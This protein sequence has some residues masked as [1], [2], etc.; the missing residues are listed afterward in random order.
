MGENPA[1][2][3]PAVWVEQDDVLNL[4]EA[5][6]GVEDIRQKLAAWLER[7]CKMPHDVAIQQAAK[8]TPYLTCPAHGGKRMLPMTCMFCGRGHM[9]E[10]HYPKTCREANCSKYRINNEVERI[11]L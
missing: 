11:Y 6:L 2:P 5:H 7:R 9:M 10:C 4:D 1:T 3:G 8:Q